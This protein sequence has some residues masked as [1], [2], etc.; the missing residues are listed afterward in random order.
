MLLLMMM[1]MLLMLLI[2]ML[3]QLLMLQR[4]PVIEHPAVAVSRL[5]TLRRRRPTELR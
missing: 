4:Q 5:R 1:L 2:L 3:L